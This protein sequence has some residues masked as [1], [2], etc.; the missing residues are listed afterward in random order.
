[1]AKDYEIKQYRNLAFNPHDQKETSG[2]YPYAVANVE[3]R[4]DSMFFAKNVINGICANLSHGSYPYQSW[5]INQQ[6]DAEITIDFG[7]LVEV[8]RVGVIASG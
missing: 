2:A 8:D 1:L 3:T 4:N 5:G 7:R 6:A